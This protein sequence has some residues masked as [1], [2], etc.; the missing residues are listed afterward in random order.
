MDGERSRPSISLRIIELRANLCRGSIDGAFF[1]VMVGSGETYLAAFVLA[2]NMGEVTAG[3]ITSIPMLAGAVVQLISPMMVRRL[4]SH[5]IWVIACAAIQAAAFIP[6]VIAALAG[7]IPK[8]AVFTLAAVYWGSGMATGPAWNTW[9]SGV[10]P[11]RLRANYF[12]RR[13]RLAH[14]AVLLGLVGGGIALQTGAA[15][16]RALQAFAILFA[17]AGL[18]RFISAGYLAAQTEPIPPD[19]SH[20]MVPARELL[21]RFRGS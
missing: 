9:M 13:S 8:I 14:V 10:V 7:H 6:L 19:Q 11:R 1:S 2:L 15:H 4:R 5:R 3:L 21:A 12:A 17:V 16:D 18:A 20:R